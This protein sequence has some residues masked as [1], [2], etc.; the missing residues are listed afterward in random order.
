MKAGRELPY[1]LTEKGKATRRA[2]YEKTKHK[3]FEQKRIKRKIYANNHPEKVRCRHLL[4]N[5]VRRGYIPKPEQDEWS[6]TM[7]FHHPDHSRPYYGVWLTR[8]EHRLVDL[9]KTPCPP[10]S[11]YTDAV[12]E[13]L[14]KDW[15]ICLAALKAVEEK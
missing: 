6:N 9:G 10:C 8:S 11:D 3:H 4:G 2:Y 13:G 7:D 14:S 15:G 12:V 5:A 1:H